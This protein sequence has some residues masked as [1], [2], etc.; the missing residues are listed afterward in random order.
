M[1]PALAFLA[2]ILPPLVL[3][4]LPPRT[5]KWRRARK[6]FWIASALAGAIVAVWIA[7]IKPLGPAGLWMGALFGLAVMA[8][9]CIHAIET[10]RSERRERRGQHEG[11]GKV[12][13]VPGIDPSKPWKM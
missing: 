12:V 8:A 7:F 3:A 1:L 6:L 11:K 13:G 10:I 2:C 9:I 5:E 4:A